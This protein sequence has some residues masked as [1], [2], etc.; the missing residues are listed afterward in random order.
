MV[1]G[2]HQGNRR[3]PLGATARPAQANALGY[4]WKN[5]DSWH[6][7][8]ERDALLSDPPAAG[9]LGEVQQPRQ[10]LLEVLMFRR[11]LL[12]LC[13]V[14]AV[15]LASAP[16]AFAGGAE[17][18]TVTEP[19]PPPVTVTTPAP[20]PVTVTTPAPAP[21]APKKAVTKKKKSSS[22]GSGGGGGGSKSSSGSNTESAAVESAE[23]RSVSFTA[24]T[25][26][27]GV[28]AG[29][30]GT[31]PGPGGSTGLAL[32]LAGGALL[33]LMGGGG[34]LARGRTHRP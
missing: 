17:T 2:G 6:L 7:S 8:G 34:L 32:G 3:E 23:V 13:S 20:P 28:Q 33:L 12:L 14:P 27:G 21:V 22:G 31:A 19:A 25:P 29:G 18:V 5:P 11:S 1:T 15:A 24:T 10:P 4:Q 26:V 16:A 9:F 30:G